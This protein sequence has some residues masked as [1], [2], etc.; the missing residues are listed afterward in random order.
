MVHAA[1][2]ERDRILAE[3]SARSARMRKDAQFLIDQQMKQLK[4]DLTKEAIEAAIGAAEKV[5]VAQIGAPD[6]QRLADEYMTTIQ[7][8]IEDEEVRA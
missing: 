2:S 7:Q 3:A 6:Q 4:T 8:V 1:E 5:M